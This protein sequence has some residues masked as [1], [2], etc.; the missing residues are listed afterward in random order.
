MGRNRFVHLKPKTAI[1]SFKK[2][3]ISFKT[4]AVNNQNFVKSIVLRIYLL[5][6]RANRKLFH[7]I[8]VKTWIFF[9]SFYWCPINCK[10]SIMNWKIRKFYKSFFCWIQIKIIAVLDTFYR[11]KKNIVIYNMAALSNKIR[12]RLVSYTTKNI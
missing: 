11:P 5:S 6:Y 1:I 8:L 2:L 7:L 4:I 10:S 12:M 3:R 9:L